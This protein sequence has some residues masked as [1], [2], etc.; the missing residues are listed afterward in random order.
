VAGCLLRLWVQI[1][2]CALISVPCEC[3]VLSLR[4]AD[5]S[6]GRVLLSVNVCV[7]VCVCVSECDSEVTVTRRPRYTKGS[8]AMRGGGISES[9]HSKG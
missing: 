5:H 8:W 7:C 3:C 4:R 9:M 6:D 1:P 2:F